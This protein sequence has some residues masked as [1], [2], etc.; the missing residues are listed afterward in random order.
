MSSASFAPEP[1]ST[2]Y[3]R[4]TFQSMQNLLA[5]VI[6]Y[7][8]EGLLA[9]EYGDQAI[10]YLLTHKFQ[11]AGIS[12]GIVLAMYLVAWLAFRQSSIA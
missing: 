12:L 2:L 7:F 8:G 10:P 11:V 6:R 4:S 5:R 1:Y 3:Q 9:V